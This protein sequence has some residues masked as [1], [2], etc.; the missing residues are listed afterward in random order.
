MMIQIP[1]LDQLS[2]IDMLDHPSLIPLWWFWMTLQLNAVFYF[3][4]DLNQDLFK[5]CL[6]LPC[7]NTHQ[8]HVCQVSVLHH[9]SSV[10]STTLI[11][12]ANSIQVHVHTTS[13]CDSQLK[14][15]LAA[16]YLQHLEWLSGQLLEEEH[17][18]FNHFSSSGSSAW[19]LH[20]V[21]FN[22]APSTIN[23]QK[24]SNTQ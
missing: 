21:H 16:L 1:L 14:R 12:A 4:H 3:L 19:S 24:V 5:C 22:S 11:D 20:T 17:D 7:T 13:P 15:H 8:I 18:A 9:A 23:T 6:N 2:F 10:L